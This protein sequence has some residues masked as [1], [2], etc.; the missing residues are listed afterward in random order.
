MFSYDFEILSKNFS[1]IDFNIP[2]G[3]STRILTGWFVFWR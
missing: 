3:S 2:I 1:A